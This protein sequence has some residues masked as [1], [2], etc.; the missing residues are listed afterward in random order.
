MTSLESFRPRSDVEVDRDARP[1]WIR[2]AVP[3]VI[4]RAR[5]RE[6]ELDLNFLDEPSKIGHFDVETVYWYYPD[7]TFADPC[8]VLGKPIRSFRL[9]T[10]PA[11]DNPLLLLNR[12]I[13]LSAKYNVRF[14]RQPH[15]LDLVD[16]LAHAARE[17]QPDSDFH[18]PLAHDAHLRAV[19]TSVRRAGHPISFLD[20]CVQ[21]GVID[22][23]LAP[24]ANALRRDPSLAV[25]LAVADTDDRFW[26]M[27]DEFVAFGSPAWRQFRREPQ[28]D[29]AS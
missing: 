6:L 16:R 9:L 10:D 24:L 1:Y 13:K 21:A 29:S 7:L 23:R 22:A 4:V 15:L 28:C 20:G 12:V 11:S 18:G 25:R 3:V 27:A 5:H 2:L 14:W 8:G 19:A 26:R 17:W